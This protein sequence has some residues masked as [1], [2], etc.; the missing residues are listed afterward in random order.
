MTAILARPAAVQ[1]QF[2][3]QTMKKNEITDELTHN[4][5]STNKQLKIK[6]NQRE[7]PHTSRRTER[8]DGQRII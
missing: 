7:L 3:T 1:S 4:K 2:S 5:S 8:T 6:M